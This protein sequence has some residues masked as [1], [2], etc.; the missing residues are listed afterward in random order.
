MLPVTNDALDFCFK[1]AHPWKDIILFERYFNFYLS[2]IITLP[3]HNLLQGYSFV[4]LLY[5][6]GIIIF[7]YLIARRLAGKIQGLLA[8]ILTSLCPLLVAW[9]TEYFSDAPC[10]FFGLAAFYF[11]LIRND[12]SKNHIKYFLCGFLLTASLF[13][14]FFGVIFIMPVLIN[15]WPYRNLKNFFFFCQGILGVMLFIAIGDH[16]FVKDFFYHLNPQNYLEYKNY[17]G[18]ALFIRKSSGKGQLLLYFFNKQELIFYSI[19]F[20]VFVIQGS[21][22][23]EYREKFDWKKRGAFCLAL[24]GLSLGIICTIV[25]LFIPGFP[26]LYHY[27]Y[28]IFIPWI[29]AFCAILGFNEEIESKKNRISKS[30]IISAFLSIFFIISI[31]TTGNL[32]SS[33]LL[34][35]SFGRIF[36]VAYFWIHVFG[37]ALVL[38][39]GNYL[40]N[41]GFRKITAFLFLIGCFV[42][43]WHNAFWAHDVPGYKREL[44]T[45]TKT[46]IEK[47]RELSKS[48]PVI[49]CD[50]SVPRGDEIMKTL[51]LSRLAKREIMHSYRRKDL[52]EILK[53]KPVPFYMLTKSGNYENLKKEAGAI[54][55]RVID[56]QDIDYFGCSFFKIVSSE[57][58]LKE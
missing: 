44:H 58:P 6:I 20:I 3:F 46:F 32:S 8:A 18:N 53:T 52:G 37:I 33:Y 29:I 57:K 12:D 34:R 42:I 15:I 45:E 10:L 11:S 50:L 30:D 4:S 1:S 16:L 49:L 55:L 39:A 40:R 38:V 35:P 31:F 51:F 23:L 2:K 13:S 14:K 26:I 19:I 56:I 28:C 41:K 21:R 43:I 47:Y 24:A 9:A 25:N 17:V 5:H 22:F 7:A 36:Y 48:S 27:N 54:G